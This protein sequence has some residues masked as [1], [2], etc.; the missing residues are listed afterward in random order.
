MEFLT[1][2]GTDLKVYLYLA[3]TA[4][5]LLI[6]WRR[7]KLTFGAVKAMNSEDASSKASLHSVIKWDV[8]TL[9]LIAAMFWVVFGA[10]GPGIQPR[11]T[12]ASA[13]GTYQKAEADLEKAK[14]DPMP[15]TKAPPLPAVDSLLKEPAGIS[16]DDE[17]KK[18]IEQAKKGH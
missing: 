11:R 16:H 3:L 4:V 6:F 14:T 1:N 7:G 9:L 10:Y 5:V 18:A 2:T 13:D 17:I 8:I 15:K 12:P